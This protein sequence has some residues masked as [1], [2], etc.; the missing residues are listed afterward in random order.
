MAKYGEEHVQRVA[1]MFAESGFDYAPHP[2]RVPN[3]HLA[4]ELGELAR[5]EGL[6]AAYHEAVMRAM[7]EESRD[8]AD[9]AE[10]RAIAIAAG[11]DPEAVDEA[12]ATRRFRPVVEESTREAHALGINAVPAF[13]L[14]E[15]FLLMGAQPHEV[16]EQV[17]REQ[18]LAA[19]A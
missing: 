12:I 3:T 18:G 19:D 17:I 13:V 7:W 16:F 15:R 2:E 9:P 8:V 1:A 5:A 11:L 10:I 6:H 4:L 14:D